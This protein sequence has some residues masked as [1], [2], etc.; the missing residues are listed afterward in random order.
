[1]TPIHSGK[2]EQGKLI[3]YNHQKYLAQLSKLDGKDIE[4]TLRQQV[5][6]RQCCGNCGRYYNQCS[7]C[8]GYQV[9]DQ[10]QSDNMTA[11]EREK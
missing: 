3:L 11:E 10:W 9:C 2:I 6:D 8:Q 7:N 4:L 5:K 1:M